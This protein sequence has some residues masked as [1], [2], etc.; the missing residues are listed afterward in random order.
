MRDLLMAWFFSGC[1]L[2]LALYALYYA[3]LYAC[4]KED[5]GDDETE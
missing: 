2:V 3:F 1:C 4:F 5:D